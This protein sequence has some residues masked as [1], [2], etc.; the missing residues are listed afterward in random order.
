MKNT[1]TIYGDFRIVKYNYIYFLKKSNEEDIPIYKVKK[2]EKWFVGTV[3]VAKQIET[4]GNSA[5]IFIPKI[6]KIEGIPIDVNEIIEDEIFI[7][8][9]GSILFHFLKRENIKIDNLNDI[10]RTVKKNSRGR[11]I[12]VDYN[13]GLCKPEILRILKDR[14][15]ECIIRGHSDN[16]MNYYNF[17]Y[18]IINIRDLQSITKKNIITKTSLFTS[19]IWLGN[20]L[21]TKLIVTLGKDGVLLYDDK[22]YLIGTIKRDVVHRVGVGDIFLAIFSSFVDL[23]LIDRIKIANIGSSISITKTNP[24]ISK[25]ELEKEMEKLDDIDVEEYEV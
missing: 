18:L 10:L 2:K 7:T 4:L 6:L 19:S 25:E 3:N 1:F 15:R 11:C 12:I 5:N 23:E 14:C 9:N 24:I 13:T 22:I 17:D 16:Y 21:N 20:I 8:E